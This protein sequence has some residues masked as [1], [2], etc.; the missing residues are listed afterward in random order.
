MKIAVSACLL[1]EC[2]RYDG[3]SRPCEAVL[4][5][6]GAHELIPVCPEQL[7]G[8]PVPHPP[9]EV[10]S[11]VR[12]PRVVDS[13]GYDR[14]SDFTAGAE[15]A[16]ALA[17][18][19]DVKLAILKERSPSCAS[20]Y[21]YD[22]T[23]SG[24]LIPGCGI[25]TRL[26]R[27]NGIRVIGESKLA[28]CTEAV[29]ATHASET[30][31]LSTERFTLRS[32]SAADAQDVFEYSKSPEVGPAAGW[33]PHRSID[34]S[35][36]FIEKIASS[37]HVFGLIEKETG[38]IVGSVG[39]I[40]DTMRKNTDAL[41]LGYALGQPWWGKGYMT[42]ASREIIRYGFE[43]LRLSLITSNHYEFNHR[44]KRVIEKCGFKYEGT[45]RGVEL[46]PDGIMQDAACYSITKE[47]YFSQ[48][49]D[50]LTE[51][52]GQAEENT[53]GQ[54]DEEDG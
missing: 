41:M 43:D 27:E 26:L 40:E 46:T 13:E 1:G 3:T 4:A 53:D 9:C 54:T 5:L 37:P 52:N 2:C 12:Y 18:E 38:H 24:N 44:S 31:T 30:P 25:T 33:V 6:K 35:L 50:A 21:L 11:S 32:L 49:L 17:Q 36:V 16:L 14:S 10:D 48:G 29:F 8:L 7:A 19:N 23:F 34:D 51:R 20:D 28:S 15:K 45:L 47:E 42:E 22:G 39:L